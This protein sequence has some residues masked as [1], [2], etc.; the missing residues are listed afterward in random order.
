MAEMQLV[1]N[2]WSQALTEVMYKVTCLFEALSIE[3]MKNMEIKH[4]SN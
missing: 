3:N 1:H 4:A 2:T